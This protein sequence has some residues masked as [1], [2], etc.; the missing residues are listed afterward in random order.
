MPPSPDESGG[1]GHAGSALKDM[2]SR[3]PSPWQSVLDPF[4]VFPGRKREM[5]LHSNSEEILFVS[6]LSP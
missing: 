6:L 3:S 2:V 5:L 1:S 4:Q